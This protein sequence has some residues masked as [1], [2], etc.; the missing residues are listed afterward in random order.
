MCLALAG[1]GGV[2]FGSG[3]GS[4]PSITRTAVEQ[5][6]RAWIKA[7]VKRKASVEAPRCYENPDEHHWRCTTDAHGKRSRTHF[8]FTATC[9][10]KHCQYKIVYRAA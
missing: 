1:C 5:Q 6:G 8:S 2:G 7:K 9:N 4:E 3:P 10:A